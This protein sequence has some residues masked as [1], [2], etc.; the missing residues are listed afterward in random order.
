MLGMVI[1]FLYVMLRSMNLR[2]R[3]LRLMMRDGIL[4]MARVG[5]VLIETS[6]ERRQVFC[7]VSRGRKWAYE[8]EP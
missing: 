5:V 3:Y 2:A 6:I 8:P 1:S 7:I 4:A